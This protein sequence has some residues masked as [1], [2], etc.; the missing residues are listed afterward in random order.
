MGSWLKKLPGMSVRRLKA[1]TE[2]AVLLDFSSTL[3]LEEE[4]LQVAK[5]LAGKIHNHSFVPVLHNRW[6]PQLLNLQ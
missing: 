3:V 4:S 5:Q 2:G 6:A 1:A